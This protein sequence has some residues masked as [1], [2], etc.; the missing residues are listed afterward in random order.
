M[1]RLNLQQHHPTKAK[2]IQRMEAMMEINQFLKFQAEQEERENKRR[3][4]EL[5]LQAK[6]KEKEREHELRII[7]LLSG[8]GASGTGVPASPNYSMYHSS[9][10]TRHPYQMPVSPHQPYQHQPPASSSVDQI[11]EDYSFDSGKHSNICKIKSI[12]T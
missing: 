8:V 4:E 2:S 7:Q 1:T 10:S 6:E 12:M 9:P 3:K 5:E 11:S